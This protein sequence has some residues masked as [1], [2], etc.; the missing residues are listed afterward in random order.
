MTTQSCHRYSFS[1]ISQYLVV[2]VCLIESK[3]RNSYHKI[4]F[5]ILPLSLQMTAWGFSRCLEHYFFV[6][7]LFIAVFCFIV[8]FHTCITHFQKLKTDFWNDF[9]R[10]WSYSTLLDETYLGKRLWHFDKQCTKKNKKLDQCKVVLLC[11]LV[12]SENDYNCSRFLL[13][14]KSSIYRTFK[15]CLGHC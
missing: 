6:F 11:S 1:W 14:Y 8:L 7:F 10:M 15:F 13:Y 12:V 4:Y 5:I 2:S 3:V 9:Y